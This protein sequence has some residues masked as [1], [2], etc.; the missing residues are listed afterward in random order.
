MSSTP[1]YSTRQEKAHITKGCEDA[2]NEDGGRCED[3]ATALP[4]DCGDD[5]KDG[6]SGPESSADIDDW[7]QAGH[8]VV[9]FLAISA[10]FPIC[11]INGY[12]GEHGRCIYAHSEG[13]V[14]EDGMVDLVPIGPSEI[15]MAYGA[16]GL[17]IFYYTTAC[18]EGQF[19]QE[20]E[21]GIRPLGP[22]IIVQWDVNDEDKIEAYTRTIYPDLGGKLEI[23]YLVITSA[24]QT[25]VEVRLKFKDVGSRSRAVYGKIK[26]NA[27]D[28]RNKSVHLFSC[29]RGRC[30]LSFPSGTTSIFPLSPSKI[31][32]PCSRLLKFHIENF[33]SWRMERE[34]EPPTPPASTQPPPVTLLPV[35]TTSP[36]PPPPPVTTHQ[37][38]GQP[39]STPPHSPANH[40]DPSSSPELLDWG[41]INEED[42]AFALVSSALRLQKEKIDGPALGPEG[43]AVAGVVSAITAVQLP[44]CTRLELGECSKAAA[45]V[46][47]PLSPRRQ[48][49]PAQAGSAAP[50]KLKSIVLAPDRHGTAGSAG[51]KPATA[52]HLS[53]GWTVVKPKRGQ[54]SPALPSSARALTR[55]SKD[56]R[57]RAL[58]PEYKKLFWG[59]CFRCLSPSHK[60]FQCREPARCISCLGIGHFAR[61]CKAG[62][63]AEGRRPHPS[64]IT[65]KPPIHSRLTFPASS[66][67]SRISFP[68][69]SY[70]EVVAAPQPDMAR[71]S[72]DYVP[73]FP[74]QRPLHGYAAL[75]AGSAMT[76]E[77]KKLR[78]KAVVIAPREPGY[79]A[80]VAE[81]SLHLHR[82]LHIPTWNIAVSRHKPE[83]F[84]ARFDYADQRDA[85]IRAG[86]VV[87]SWTTFI[88]QP[89]RL[90]STTR[91]AS[92][93]YHVKLYIENLPMHA[94]SEEGFKQLLGDVCVFDRMDVDTFSQ[95]NTEIFACLAWMQ[96]PDR[97]HR[98]KT[99][100]FFHEAAGK[101][102]GMNGAVPD[103]SEAAQPPDGAEADILIHLDHYYNWTPTAA[104]TPSSGVSGLP[105]SGSSDDSADFPV[106]K[107]FDWSRGVVDGHQ[108]APPPRHQPAPP[109]RRQPDEPCH[110]PP[111]RA[112][113]DDDYDDNPPSRDWRS[114]YYGRS[115][116]IDD[117]PRGL[118]GNNTV[119]ERTRSPHR[120]HGGR[121]RQDRDD[122]PTSMAGR[123]RAAVRSPP[124]SRGRDPLRRDDD[125]WERRRSSSPAHRA[126]SPKSDMKAATSTVNVREPAH[127]L[128][129]M[130]A[131]DAPPPPSM[132]PDPFMDYL[133]N[134]CH[135][136]AAFDNFHFRQEGDPML[137]EMAQCAGS[138]INLVDLTVITTCESHEDDKNLKFS[139]EFTRGITS[140]EREVDDA[141]VE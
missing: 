70:A 52:Q 118:S 17:E 66:I 14:Q 117:F 80:S 54:R 76:A 11:A 53:Q 90:G 9:Q 22:R 24:V 6:G 60:L 133:A 37:A 45:G 127:D 131:I 129:H 111:P 58:S 86:S 122:V 119:R 109:P 40:S 114:G 39:L 56:G 82:Q 23:T 12:D 115:R 7:P 101:S 110:G 65:H 87:I 107:R 51:Q 41:S 8:R 3:G 89:W 10:N 141:G 68:P 20:D 69:L 42:G 13:E 128:H 33:F 16:I 102:R 19:V 2:A 48:P 47:A 67:H 79:N 96:N 116:P 1:E 28:Y 50:A 73:G 71:R 30:C 38:T 93:F 78:R 126:R 97:L 92:W 95:E 136:A 83:D 139:L 15:L 49:R 125:G 57:P 85:A 123:G 134:L 75:V 4:D 113:R 108:P 18:D 137:H 35:R 29:D 26:A 5:P 103:A 81:M 99:S 104:R 64:L 43:V 112:Y 91:P 36:P 25:S 121:R 27:I 61:N 98:S 138:L 72:D 62:P 120:G 44:S 46:K 124:T 34:R 77:Y 55:R 140:Q 130:I 132:H 88:I 63:V 105:S 74:L 21:G 84:L 59:K 32:L 106:Y 31:A 94:W 100:S 135:E